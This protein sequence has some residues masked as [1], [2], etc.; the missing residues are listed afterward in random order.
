[1]NAEKKIVTIGIMAIAIVLISSSLYAILAST[2]TTN[3]TTTIEHILAVSG[4]GT[5][6]VNP[7]LARIVLSVVTEG[8]TTS[9]TVAQNA[10]IVNQMIK[11]LSDIGIT[12]ENVQTTGYNI[13]PVY[14]YPN[15]GSQPYI[16]GYRV[17]HSLEVSVKDA[18]MTQLGIRAGNIIDEAV[19]AGINQVSG[20]Q[21]TVAEQTLKQ[22]KDQALQLAISDASGKA[23]ITANA[24]GV[25]IVGVQSVSESSPNTYPVFYTADVKEGRST[26]FIPGEVTVSSTINIVYIIN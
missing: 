13:Y 22:L 5:I 7:D 24:L 6:K 25:K 20:V 23:N 1:L 17:S 9:D 12:K 4:M 8:K 2:P 3:S 26:T 18:N 16:T 21:F 10:E 19:A 11:K 14:N 15:D